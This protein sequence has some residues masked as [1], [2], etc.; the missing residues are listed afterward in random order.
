MMNF[1]GIILDNINIVLIDAPTI[2]KGSVNKNRDGS[3]TIFL[4]ARHSYEQQRITLEHELQHIKNGDFDKSDVQEIEYHAHTTHEETINNKIS[5]NE[6][7]TKMIQR[8]KK[9][10]R[11]KETPNPL[12]FLEENSIFQRAENKWLYG[13][14][15]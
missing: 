11:I 9:R 1:E 15:F 8:R 2:I 7:I 6:Y 10:Q 4:N 12:G 3:S 13:N 5:A 14:D